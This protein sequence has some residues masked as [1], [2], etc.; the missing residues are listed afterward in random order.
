MGLVHIYCGDG[1]GKSTAAAGLSLR[2]LGRG[3]KVL[4]LQF[5]KNGRSGELGPLE[6]LGAEVRSGMPKEASGF[7]WT[8]S[9]KQLAILREAQNERLSEAFTFLD[10]NR[11]KGGVIVLDEALASLQLDLLD[12]A[13]V[14]DLIS[15]VKAA[16]KGPDLVLT[17]REASEK[18][19]AEADYLSRI[20]ALRH[21]Y[22]RG[23][24]ARIGIEF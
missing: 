19:A 16:E 7:T 2:S 24:E 9:E 11:E 15:R 17:G 8:M 22:E 10:E 13:Q 23:I 14:F 3:R 18:L 1:K 12:E 20:E 5:L 6:Q 21:P 4:F